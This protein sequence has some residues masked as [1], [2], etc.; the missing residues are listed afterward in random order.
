M[1]ALEILCTRP[2]S[3]TKETLKQLKVILDQNGFSE[4]YLKTAYKDITN[5]D[6]VTD[7][8]GFV[9]QNALGSSLESNEE[10][11]KRAMQKIKKEYKLTKPQENWLK[12]IESVMLKEVVI[13]IETLDTG[14]F[15]ANGGGFTRLNEKVF[16]GI[17][18]EIITKIKTYMFEDIA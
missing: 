10:R 1:Q 3:L 8:I 18:G 2:Q 7:I 14:A 13:D 9:R 4:E 6:I 5:E 15:K 12:R 17:L 16:G 11:V